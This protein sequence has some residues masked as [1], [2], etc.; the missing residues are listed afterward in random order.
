MNRLWKEQTM[1]PAEIQPAWDAADEIE[2]DEF[3][4]GSV[5][6]HVHMW[7]SDMWQDAIKNDSY[8]E[9]RSVYDSLYG[10]VQTANLCGNVDLYAALSTLS[11]IAHEHRLSK[12]RRAA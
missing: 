6:Y 3:P 8:D 1:H 2:E 10:A 5:E 7:V 4:R 9:W 11:S 12:I